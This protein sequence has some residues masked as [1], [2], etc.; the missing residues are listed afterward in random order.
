MGETQTHHEIE[1][2]DERTVFSLRGYKRLDIQDRQ[3]KASICKRYK[4]QATYT[5]K[6]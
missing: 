6:I 2:L 3:S 1:A 4:N 5:D